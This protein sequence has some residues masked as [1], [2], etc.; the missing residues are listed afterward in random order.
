MSLEDKFKQKAAKAHLGTTYSQAF[1]KNETD[2][3]AVIAKNI[4][5]DMIDENPDNEQVFCMNDVEYYAEGI[6]EEG[7]AG[8]IWVFDKGNG[9]YEI[10]SGHQ[11]FRAVQKLRE[12]DSTVTT[13]PCIISK[14]PDEISKS[15]RLLSSNI[16]N[17]RLSPMEWARAI[18]YYKQNVL[19]PLKDQGKKPQGK[20]RDLC[21][22][23]CNMS[24]TTVAR[25]EALMKLSTELQDILEHNDQYIPYTSLYEA[26][27]LS[28]EAQSI[29]AHKINSEI[30]NKDEEVILAM[31]VGASIKAMIKQLKIQESKG[32]TTEQP[33]NTP[34][35]E[36]ATVDGHLKNMTKQLVRIAS[37]ERIIM[38]NKDDVRQYI[39]TMKEMIKN[40]EEKL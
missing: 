18:E 17:R 32:E 25:Y 9:R 1:R 2:K 13:I 34:K 36:K 8:A 3:N 26:A 24:P 30:L 37:S 27:T 29:L 11:R 12:T 35:Q 23:F 14:M 31:N 10:S 6:K 15:I 39:E 28:E 7:F 33:E 5:L 21:A 16:R 38:E 40:I 20:T 22:R 4:P 19:E